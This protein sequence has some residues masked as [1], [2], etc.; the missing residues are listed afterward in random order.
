ME[1]IEISFAVKYFLNFIQ[2]IELPLPNCQILFWLVF[3]ILT[4]PINITVSNW[5]LQSLLL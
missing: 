4:V 2:G 5:I 1:I 3:V